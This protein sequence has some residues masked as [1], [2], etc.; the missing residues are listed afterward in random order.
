MAKQTK[1]NKQ[2]R[3]AVE[4]G[5]VYS[6][7]DAVKVVK[8]CATSKF[9]ETIEVS[10]NLNVDPRHADQMV[11]GALSLPHGIGKQKRVVAFC[12]D[13]KTDDAKQAGAIEAGGD[14]LIKKV[15]DG[16][17]DFDDVW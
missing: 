10:M 3:A 11:R 1:R 6:L 5:K 12:G 14:A 9:D 2:A 15:Q 13:D 16:W 4:A 8:E 17:M 7:S